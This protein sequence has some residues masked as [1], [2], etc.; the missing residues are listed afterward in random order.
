MEEKLG[1]AVMGGHGEGSPATAGVVSSMGTPMNDGRCSSYLLFHD[2]PRPCAQ[3]LL[4]RDGWSA[5]TS[6]VEVADRMLV[7]TKL[8]GALQR[9]AFAKRLATAALLG[10]TDE[11]M[12]FLAVLVRLL[13]R[14][15][16]LRGM[17]E[18]EI[19]GSPAGRVSHW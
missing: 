12:G 19:G 14:H 18:H 2:Y 6:I 4:L 17:L 16:A 1:G 10:A 11:A 3:A 5:G 15:A 8:I 7:G 9:T 13:R